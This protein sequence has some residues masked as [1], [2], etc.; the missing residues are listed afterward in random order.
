M[1]A[2]KVLLVDDDIDFG[3][4]ICTGL[5]SLGYE[6]HFQNSLIAIEEVIARFSPA[7]IVLDVE[8]GKENGIEKAKEIMRKF[9]S[10]PVLFV[11]SHTD[12]SYVTE[13]IAAGG[14][15][16]L[17]KP[18]D[19][20]ELDAYLIRFTKKQFVS[21]QIVLGNYVFDTQTSQLFY[22]QTFLKQLSPLERNALVLFWENVN[23]SVSLTTLSHSL[24]GKD[25]STDIE[26]CIYNM[27]SKLRKL[28]NQDSRVSIQ[29]LKG[30]GYQL[31][32]S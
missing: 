27:I 21:N 5:S 30:V 22:N 24:W 19:V 3:H 25:F 13:G 14:V 12:I 20:R 1:K 18:F 7:I 23:T 16:Y 28:F 6:I 9:P 26:A 2:L 4:I 32:V 31:R 10:I 11:S 15:N 17:R 8:I 29:T